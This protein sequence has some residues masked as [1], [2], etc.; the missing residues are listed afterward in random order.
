MRRFAWI[1]AVLVV[2]AGCAGSFVPTSGEVQESQIASLAPAALFATP[3]L[4]PTRFV[5][6]DGVA[7]PLRTWMPDEAPRAVILALHGF[8]DYSNAFS[9]PAP[10]WAAAGIATYAYDQRGFGAAPG[11]GRW[12]GGETLAA[13][14]LTAAR[15]LRQRYP[16]T[17]LYL[18]GESM[19]GA[20]SIMAA[21]ATQSPPVDGV[22][23][24]APAVWGRQTMNFWQRA[25]LWFASLAPAIEVSARDLPVKVRASDNI[26]MLRAFSA[27]PLVIK[28]TRAEA[29][30]G[31]VDLM[32]AALDAASRLTIPAL[33]LYGEH[34]EIVPRHPVAR[35]VASLPRQA[36]GRQKVA[37]YPDGWH[38]LLRDLGRAV[39]TKDIA[40][41]V[42][43]P[44]A[45]LPSGADGE[46]RYLLTGE[47]P[48]VAAL[49]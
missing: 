24:V 37:L 5:T 9:M 46:A 6:A 27:D 11:R 32:G 30:T 42:L 48:A 31:L 12:Y 28:S 15:L 20:V 19:G 43:D 7:L 35:M 13:D 39:P 26:A 1:L 21:T 25:G 38:M 2:A 49:R 34:D 44:S 3:E 14:A 40:A 33:V 17:P 22:I 8:N 18:L 16:D 36:R 45:P 23:L 4:A 10:A 47:R 41:W 29:V